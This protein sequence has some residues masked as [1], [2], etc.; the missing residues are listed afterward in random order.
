MELSEL[1]R[2]VDTAA[3]VTVNSV[4]EL[5]VVIQNRVREKAGIQERGYP[6]S[7]RSLAGLYNRVA[8]RLGTNL[9]S[10]VGEMHNERM[11]E[12]QFAPNGG[13]Y[14][15]AIYVAEQL[16]RNA[17]DQVEANEAGVKDTY[18]IEQRYLELM[19]HM[20]KS[21]HELMYPPKKP[22]ETESGTDC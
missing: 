20:I 7:Y 10:V 3:L 4:H 15:F 17:T 2:P 1:T 16:A 11:V 22:K 5:K 13:R 19:Q 8:T 21:D 9:D 18:K 14:L 6:T 12:L